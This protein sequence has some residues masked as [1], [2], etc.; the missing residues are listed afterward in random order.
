MTCP[1]CAAPIVL[2]LILCGTCWGRL[3]SDLKAKLVWHHPD[4]AK[5]RKVPVKA[6][7]YDALLRQA[8]EH[9]RY[10]ST[11]HG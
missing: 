1:H 9:L 7:V 6:G 3:P 4:V 10:L 11:G 2:G 5:T 8:T